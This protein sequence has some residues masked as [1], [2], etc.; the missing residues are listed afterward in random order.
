MMCTVQRTLLLPGCGQAA[1]SL[2]TIIARLAN[3]KAFT[4][5]HTANNT[6]LPQYA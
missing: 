6:Q 4:M 5:G 2:A 3:N 1:A